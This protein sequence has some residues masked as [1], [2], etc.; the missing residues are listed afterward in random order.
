MVLAHLSSMVS[1]SGIA[2]VS[3]TVTCPS[4]AAI[5]W[6]VS[7]EQLTV[8]IAWVLASAEVQQ[9]PRGVEERV[10]LLEMARDERADVRHRAFLPEAC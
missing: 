6:P 4:C 7:P 10:E 1:K 3:L 9:I 2:R 8:G 5:Q